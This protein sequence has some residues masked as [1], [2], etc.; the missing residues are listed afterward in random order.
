MKKLIS[1]A[2]ILLLFLAACSNG[3][4]DSNSNSNEKLKVVTT[5]S[6]LYDMVK[7]AGGDNV[8]IHS[9]VPVGQ[10]P[11]EYEVKPKDIKKL[12]DA[13]VILYNGL[14][15]ETGNGW[16]EKALEQAGKSLK[17][18]KVIAVSKDVKP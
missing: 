1:I 11:H 7:N 8:E 6:I 16:F 5:N 17:D 15:L 13:D 9:I 3:K 4:S 14:N 2:L 10:D 12:T 18:K